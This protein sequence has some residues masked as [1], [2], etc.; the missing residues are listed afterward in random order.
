MTESFVGYVDL[1]LLIA[2]PFGRL[3]SRDQLE[4][5]QLSSVYIGH[6][7]FLPFFYNIYKKNGDNEK[8]QHPKFPNSLLTNVCEYRLEIFRALSE[9]FIKMSE[10]LA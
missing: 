2:F 6:S 8:E 5:I 1:L 9:I 3:K 10:V 7:G 4:V